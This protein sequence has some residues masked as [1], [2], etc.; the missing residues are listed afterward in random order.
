MLQ[1]IDEVNLTANVNI[2][3]F[4]HTLI[5]ETERMHE[6]ENKVKKVE[7]VVDEISLVFSRIL[8][9]LQPQNMKTRY[10][11]VKREDLVN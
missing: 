5:E 7:R 1:V 4:E 9:Q 10:I 8:Y 6:K 11:E 2:E 3:F